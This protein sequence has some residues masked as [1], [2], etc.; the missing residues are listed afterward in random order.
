MCMSAQIRLSNVIDLQELQQCRISVV[1]LGFVFYMKLQNLLFFWITAQIFCISD[2]AYISRS[3]PSGFCI[4]H[5]LI[6][7]ATRQRFRMC[8]ESWRIVQLSR[9]H[10]RTFVGK[11]SRIENFSRK[12]QNDSSRYI[13]SW[14]LLPI[15][16]GR[17]EH[18]RLAQLTPCRGDSSKRVKSPL[19]SFCQ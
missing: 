12:M 10:R 9:F 14:F 11:L 1:H 16:L 18:W 6:A 5:G 13:A 15:K 3:E 19:I 17:L 2:T 4:Q 7:Y 8:T